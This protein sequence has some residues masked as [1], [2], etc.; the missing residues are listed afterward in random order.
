MPQTFLAHDKLAT[1]DELRYLLVQLNTKRFVEWYQLSKSCKEH[2]FH[3]AFTFDN[4]IEFL[5]SIDIINPIDNGIVNLKQKIDFTI[6]NSD[7]EL[8]LFLLEKLMQLLN[9]E[10][11][12]ET[13]FQSDVISQHKEGI[14][15]NIHKIPV[16]FSFMKVFLLHFKIVETFNHNPKTFVV[17]VSFQGY[18]SKTILI[19]KVKQTT[20]ENKPMKFFVS[21]SSKDEK[22][23]DELKKHFK[24]VIDNGLMDYWDGKI[25]LPGEYWDTEIK[26]KL[27]EA[28][29]ILLLISVDFMNSDYIN[30]VELKHALEREKQGLVKIIPILV[31]TCD[32]ESS[33][34]NNRH[35][36][37]VGKKPIEEWDNKEAAYVNIVEQI[38]KIL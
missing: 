27:E 32:F 26:K 13:I 38:K 28:D 29:V 30:N 33:P 12:K 24:G 14:L 11:L 21:Y 31:R 19:K 1:L 23:K 20:S 35:S 36:L 34:L 7:Y 18:F 25:I 10:K 8:G 37:P 2:S 17:T 15:V 4:T 9:A 6:L 16:A 3:F 22:Y 5:Q